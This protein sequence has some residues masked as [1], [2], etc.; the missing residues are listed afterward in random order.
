MQGR[1]L[2]ICFC[3]SGANGVDRD[4]SRYF[5]Y[6]QQP[7]RFR[8]LA[9]ELFD[10]LLQIAVSHGASPDPLIAL[11]ASGVLGEAAFLRHKV[12]KETS[13][14]PAWSAALVNSVADAD[15]VFVD[16]ERG[17]QGNRLTTRHVALAEIAA[18]RAKNR[19]LIIGHHQSGRKGEVKYLADRMKSLGFGIVEIVR[20]RLVAS[21]LFVILDQD[22][23]MSD[24]I[25]IFAR[26]WGNWVKSYRF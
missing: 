16:P 7:D 26:R 2:A 1:R 4:R 19:A 8:H 9:P 17:I 14:R 25:A 20:L 23:A 6:L 13:L 10:Q 24:A 5:Q 11:R 3:V 22:D 12:P 15:L 18:L 21:Y